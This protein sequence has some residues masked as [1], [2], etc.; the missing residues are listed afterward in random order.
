MLA[1]YGINSL[2]QGISKK[3]ATIASVHDKEAAVNYFTFDNNQRVSYDDKTT[4]KQKLSWADE[5]GL[6]GTM[7][8][9][10][11]LGMNQHLFIWPSG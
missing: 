1:Y 10:S 6:G 7:V 5:V 9:A 8:W 2:L 3:R 11:N 4:F